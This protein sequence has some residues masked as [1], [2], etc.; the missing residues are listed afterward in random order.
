M[1][2]T[3]LTGKIAVPNSSIFG[4]AAGIDIST[5]ATKITIGTN[6]DGINDANEF[7]VISGN[8]GRGIDTESVGVVIAGNLI[9]TDITG[10]LPVG[11]VD[12]GVPVHGGS[13]NV[14][15]NDDGDGDSG[16]SYEL[17]FFT[18]D[19]YLGSHS[20]VGTGVSE[21]FNAIVGTTVNG[22]LVSATATRA[23]TETSEFSAAII[24]STAVPPAID[25]ESLIV[26]IKPVVVDTEEVTFRLPTTTVNEGTEI[27]LDGQ[28][29]VPSPNHRVT[30]FWGDGTS[31]DSVTDGFYIRD[32]GF[33]APHTYSDNLP[34]GTPPDDYT[35]RVIVT[36]T[37]T[38]AS[39]LATRMVTVANRLTWSIEWEIRL[40][41]S[42][43][44]S[45]AELI[46]A[47]RFSK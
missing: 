36:D 40:I 42:G 45:F 25:Q 14:G 27:L 37:V 46:L 35:I 23:G 16:V 19:R 12:T 11:N 8:A 15:S 41:G 17:D 13:A 39:G 9:G 26:T 30:I 3:D 28:F 38:G 6:N 47:P 7:N 1:I 18:G 33:S 2:G 20:L 4:S 5:A 10:T 29:V 44:S 24:A 32:I 22:E 31:S 34:S 43:G 21:T